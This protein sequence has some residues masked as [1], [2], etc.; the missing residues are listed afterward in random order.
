MSRTTPQFTPREEATK[1]Y[2]SVP[3]LTNPVLSVEV[4]TVIA[5]LLPITACFILLV[6]FMMGGGITPA[7]I[8]VA[9]R[10]GGTVSGG[11]LLAFSLIGGVILQN[12]YLSYYKMTDTQIT[13]D[14]MR[15]SEPFSL[16]RW[17]RTKPLAV[18]PPAEAGKTVSKTLA[19]HDIQKI[20]SIPSV[21]LI[22]ISAKNS[23]GLMKVYCADRV[24][25]EKVK[26]HVL[27][28]SGVQG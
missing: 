9:F 27:K 15:S 10:V 24:M 8:G 22:T 7:Q 26:L 12:R 17:F 18:L 6:Q 23:G 19:L 28:A 14:I 11:L 5:A 1:W 21:N 4:L 16:R 20:K 3:I 2:V 13:N 25:F